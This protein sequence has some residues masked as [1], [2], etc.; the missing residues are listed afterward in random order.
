MLIINNI[1][2]SLKSSDN[3]Y[4]NVH[5]AWCNAMTFMDKIASGM[6]LS[7]ETPDVLLGLSSWHLYPDMAVLPGETKHVSQNDSLVPT[8]AVVTDG[9]S[10]ENSGRGNGLTWTIPLATLKYYG[11]PK[12]VTSCT[13]VNSLLVPFEKCVQVAIGCLVH[14]WESAGVPEDVLQ[15]LIALSDRCELERKFKHPSSLNENPIPGWIN[16]LAEQGRRYLIAKEQER[17][18]ILRFI[19]LGRI[20]FR[21]FLDNTALIPNAF[22]FSDFHTFFESHNLSD[23]IKIKFL[24]YLCKECASSPNIQGLLLY[25]RSI[26]G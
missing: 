7:I 25:S 10:S 15:F 3:L 23:H 18:D 14:T 26:I 8:G 4:T 17:R 16:L 21:S 11:R 19:N 5:D 13:S 24:R 6:A 22:G 2:R 9:L 1:D 20:R 12:P